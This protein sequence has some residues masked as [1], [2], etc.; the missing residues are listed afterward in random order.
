MVR[1]DHIQMVDTQLAQDTFIMYVLHFQS[2][3]TEKLTINKLIF[4]CKIPVVCI[5]IH[6]QYPCMITHS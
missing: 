3:M 1:N 4:N 6:S 2:Q 5:H